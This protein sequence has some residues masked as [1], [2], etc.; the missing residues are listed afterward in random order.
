MAINNNHR[1]RNLTEINRL[2]KFT[3]KTLAHRKGYGPCE[4]TVVEG[5]IE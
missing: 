4:I 5:S 2:A 1:Y 3:H